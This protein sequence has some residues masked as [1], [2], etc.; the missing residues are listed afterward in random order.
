MSGSSAV[1]GVSPSG[2]GQNSAT[3]RASWIDRLAALQH[4]AALAYVTIFILQLRRI[5]NIWNYHDLTSGDTTSYFKDAWGWYAAHTVNIAWSPVYTM[6]YGSLL[7]LT[8]DA[9]IV[10]TL[11]RVLIVLAA[12]MLVLAIMRQLLPATLAWLAAAWWAILPINFNTLYEVHLFALLPIAVAWLIALQRSRGER[13]TWSRAVVLALLVATTILV[14]NEYIIA[15]G[16]F[17][18]ICLVVEWRIGKK[19]APAARDRWRKRTAIIYLLPMLACAATVI[20]FYSISTYKFGSK[21]HPLGEA[22]EVKHTLNMAQVYAFGYQQRH[23]EWTASPW[24][25]CGKLCQTVFHVSYPTLGQMVRNNPRAL[26]RHILWNISLVPNGWQL[27]MLNTSSGTVD[28]DYEPQAMSLTWPLY[29][30]IAIGVVVLAGFV[31]WLFERKKWREWF[32]QRGMGWLAMLAVISVGPAVVITQRPRPSYF[33]TVSVFTMAVVGTAVWILIRRLRIGRYEWILMLPI[34]LIGWRYVPTYYLH[35]ARPIHDDYERLA[36]YG[37]LMAKPKVRCLAGFSPTEMNSYICH[38]KGTEFAYSL[39]FPGYTGQIPLT[40]FFA[41]K[42]LNLVYLNDWSVGMLRYYAP[43]ALE[44][45]MAEG[46]KDGWILLASGREREPA[47]KA[48]QH[49]FFFART[50]QP[51]DG[52]TWQ[53]NNPIDAAALLPMAPPTAIAKRVRN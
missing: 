33:F 4:S 25:D 37:Y 30:S 43:G 27:L 39:M 42:R 50:V 51:T 15:S 28:P 23:P 3:S 32:S 22:L 13:A 14:R 16:V 2:T 38:G 31:V 9:Y 53:P 18:L 11:H 41:Q 7:S 10:T 17:F 44:K 26:W 1:I 47:T 49:W 35:A 20:G 46:G 6:Y 5:W 45:F 24:I 52:P 29:V 21:L 19:L 12:S 8:R 34:M 36:P 40:Q 48:P